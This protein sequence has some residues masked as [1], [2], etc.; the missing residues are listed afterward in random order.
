MIRQNNECDFYEHE[1]YF[2]GQMFEVNWEPRDSKID[3]LD[4]TIHDVPLNK[5]F[6]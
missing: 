2:I 6:A 1:L 5:Y 3:F 4:G